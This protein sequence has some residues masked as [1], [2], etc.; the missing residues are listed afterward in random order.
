M[1]VYY[2]LKESYR[3]RGWE[4]LPFALVNGDSGMVQFCTKEMFEFL[5][6]CD[7]QTDLFLD[8]LTTEGKR[9][10]QL[11]LEH[12]IIEATG[13]I[14][15]ISDKQHYHRYDCRYMGKAH[16]AITGRCNYRC[17]H[18]YLSAPE[19]VYGELSLEQCKHIID[20]L[21][22]AG[23]SRVNLTGG[24][25]LCRK[26][27][28]QLVDYLSQHRIHIDQ[29]YS[30]GAL[31]NE[32]LLDKIEKRGI[33][34]EFALSFDGIRWHDWLRGVK[35]SENHMM[36]VF[37]M[38]RERNYPMFVEMA[39]HRRNVETLRETLDLLNQEKVGALKISPVFP[40]G[41]WANEPEKYTLGKKEVYQLY[42]DCLPFIRSK[43]F[44]MDIQFDGFVTYDGAT[45]SISYGRFAPCEE[46]NLKNTAVCLGMRRSLYITPEGKVLPCAP[47]TGSEIE[48][49]MPSLLET[50]L[51]SILNHSSYWDLADC[52]LNQLKELGESCRDCRYLLACKGACRARAVMSYSD[53]YAPDE[54]ACYYFHN[55]YEQKI[56]EIWNS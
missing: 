15:P 44:D 52:R 6:R 38:L 40:A 48:K 28:F 29:I 43:Q 37:R 36:D 13:C 18:C 51:V 47:M 42:L 46:I 56:K 8:I 22:S 31:I 49:Q 4:K 9:I 53:F 5:L 27:F 33:H 1:A 3:L 20:E 24:E 54:W 12:G 21:A 34:P 32:R 50:P 41:L 7:G 16:W 39:L 55:N 35:G 19:A 30:N 23:I 25:A 2:K 14:S 11:L 45:R 17:R 26:D 10:E